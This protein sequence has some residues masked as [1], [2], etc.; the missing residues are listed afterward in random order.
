MGGG[1]RLSP[2]S[3]S[4]SW[5]E[6]G[7]APIIYLKQLCATDKCQHLFQQHAYSYNG[8]HFLL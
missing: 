3:L 1:G 2:F 6:C 7:T 8:A 4:F 5:M